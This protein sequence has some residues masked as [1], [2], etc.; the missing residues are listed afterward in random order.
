MV[1]AEQFRE[2]VVGGVAVVVFGVRLGAGDV[3]RGDLGLVLG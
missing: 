2:V 1:A 3:G